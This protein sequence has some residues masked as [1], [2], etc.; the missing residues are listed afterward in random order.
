[1]ILEKYKGHV[2]EVYD[3]KIGHGWRAILVDVETTGV[4]FYNIASNTTMYMPFSANFMITKDGK[5][6]DKKDED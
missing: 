1:M 4:L 5:P 6:E 2:V 3:S